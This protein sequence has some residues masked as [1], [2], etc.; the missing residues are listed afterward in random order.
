MS[1]EPATC[2]RCGAPKASGPECPR[3]GVLYAKARP[4]DL[5]PP[6]LPGA[7][8][9]SGVVLFEDDREGRSQIYAGALR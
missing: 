2:P 5:P 8:G 4:R 7:P 6:E 3:C 1:P 9:A